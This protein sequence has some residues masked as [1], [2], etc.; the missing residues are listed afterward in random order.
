MVEPGLYLIAACL[1]AMHHLLVAIVPRFIRNYVDSTVT[2]ARVRNIGGPSKFRRNRASPSGTLRPDLRPGD[3][4]R[5]VDS[6][7]SGVVGTQ[8]TAK[9]T[10]HSTTSKNS[11]G[12]APMDL[13]ERPAGRND[14]SMLPPD[15]MR[16]IQAGEGIIVRTDIITQE[17]NIEKILGI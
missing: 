9:T 3:F 13:E 16:R 5:L 7:G 2:K 12:M 1:P 14:M 6:N 17:E 4:T 10:S 15:D 11:E 8:A